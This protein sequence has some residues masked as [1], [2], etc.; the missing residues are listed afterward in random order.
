MIITLLDFNLK[1]IRY[2]IINVSKL[3]NYFITIIM[4]VAANTRWEVKTASF[5][6]LFQHTRKEKRFVICQRKN[7]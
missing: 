2:T 4:K 1:D 7:K 5:K 3:A 6:R